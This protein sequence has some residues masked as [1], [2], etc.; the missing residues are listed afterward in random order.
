[1][2]DPVTAPTATEQPTPGVRRG[3]EAAVGP[4]GG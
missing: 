4:D 1:M 3:T 2:S